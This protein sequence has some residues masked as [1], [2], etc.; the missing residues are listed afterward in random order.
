VH[1]LAELDAGT[2][3]ASDEL[4]ALRGN[5]VWRGVVDEEGPLGVDLPEA[6][7]L[8]PGENAA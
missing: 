6:V 5:L 1:G 3:G 4:D 2:A 7:L 8:G